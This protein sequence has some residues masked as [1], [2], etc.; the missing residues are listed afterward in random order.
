MNQRFVDARSDVK[1]MKSAHSK[2]ARTKL[3]SRENLREEHIKQKKSVKL[4]LQNLLKE[5]YKEILEQSFSSP[6]LLRKDKD[7][8]HKG[9]W[10]YCLY[11]GII[12]QFDRPGYPDDEMIRKISSP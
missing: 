12:Y 9:D 10:R 7:Y 11:Q 8:D 6:I 2:L 4:Q 3:P 1:A 5:V